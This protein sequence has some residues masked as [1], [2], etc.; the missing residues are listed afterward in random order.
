MRAQQQRKTI[1]GRVQ[2]VLGMQHEAAAVGGRFR[3][4]GAHDRMH[5]EAALSCPTKPAIFRSAPLK[6]DNALLCC[7]RLT[8]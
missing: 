7:I 2:H 3:Q 5:F 6:R 1:T 8:S 4:F